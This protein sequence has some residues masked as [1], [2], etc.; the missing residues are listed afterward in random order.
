MMAGLHKGSRRELLGG[1]VGKGAMIGWS[2]AG[3]K[4]G[5]RQNERRREQELM[6]FIF[7]RP[8][9]A[10]SRQDFIWRQNWAPWRWSQ[11]QGP[12]GPSY[13]NI[14]GWRAIASW[15]V[16]MEGSYVQ[17]SS[18]PF[19]YQTETQVSS[20]LQQEWGNKMEGND[21]QLPVISFPHCSQPDLC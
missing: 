21:V 3:G 6:H 12:S 16:V 11:A 10:K 15:I 7:N 2:G 14:L 9:D 4:E 19:M 1:V 8:E 18:E 17:M 13:A 5:P 20:P